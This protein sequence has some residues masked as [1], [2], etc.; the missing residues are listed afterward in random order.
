MKYDQKLMCGVLDVSI[1]LTL[2]AL[3]SF[4]F[5]ETL[6]AHNDFFFPITSD[7]QV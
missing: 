2:R 1:I 6:V 7:I 4:R 5:C 3:T